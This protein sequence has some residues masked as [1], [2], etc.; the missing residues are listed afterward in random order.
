MTEI[1]RRARRVR[2]TLRKAVA[3]DLERK[4]RMGQY[5]IVFQNDKVV[6]IEPEQISQL[7]KI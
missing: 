2:E 3:N 1:Q 4:R 7:T 5:A 6:R